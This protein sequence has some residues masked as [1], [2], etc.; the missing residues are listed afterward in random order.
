[1]L[2]TSTMARLCATT[3]WFFEANSLLLRWGRYNERRAA[4]RVA[5]AA[6]ASC[7]IAVNRRRGG[8]SHSEDGIDRATQLLQLLLRLVANLVEVAVEHDV[9][10]RSLALQVVRCDALLVL[11]DLHQVLEGGLSWCRHVDY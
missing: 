7:S 8:H 2:E 10:S 6:S 3:S 11:D 5:L 4:V 9:S 1:M